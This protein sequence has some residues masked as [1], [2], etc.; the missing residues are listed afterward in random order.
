MIFLK[1]GIVVARGSRCCTSHLCEDGLA[2]KLFDHIRVSKPDRW[3]ID[4]DE[5]QI[6][7]EDIR[8]IL[9][10]QK[11]FDFDDPSCFSDEGYQAIVGLRK[12][13]FNHLVNTVS[14]MRNSHVRSVRVAVAVFL[15]KLRL[16]LSNRV[17]A[18]LFNLENKRV[19][20]HI[21]NQVRKALMKDF[22]PYHLGLK[23]ITRQTAIEEHQTAIATI[24]HTN[25]P[26]Q[27]CVIADTTYLFIQKSTNNQIQRKSYS[28]HK[29]R[30]LV[31]PMILTTTDG[32]ILCSLGTF[33]S[34]YKNNDASIL[35]HCLYT[36]EQDIIHWLHKD[37][38]LI[39]DR[40][41]R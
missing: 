28:M 1:C 16:G 18:V 29:H 17:L 15:A 4:S 21:N 24:L 23:H 34:D 2:I 22:V 26:D 33:F 12:E 25:K 40:G 37:D 38:I 27:L 31:K 20:S 8:I 13:Q 9:F 36:N 11:K 39:V 10:K 14:S 5:F 41:F 32:Y 19:V 35:K 6:F 30:N 7:V 3:K